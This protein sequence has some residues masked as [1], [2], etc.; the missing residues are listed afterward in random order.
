MLDFKADQ[1]ECERFF[2]SSERS[3]EQCLQAKGWKRNRR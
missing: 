1:A 2:G 3:Q